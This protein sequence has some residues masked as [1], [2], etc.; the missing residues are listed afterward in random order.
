MYIG[1]R[2]STDDFLWNVQDHMGYCEDSP[3]LDPFIYCWKTLDDWDFSKIVTTACNVE[4]ERINSIVSYD[5]Y[6]KDVNENNGDDFV[7]FLDER[8]ANKFY[9]LNEKLKPYSRKPGFNI[10]LS[11]FQDFV[12]SLVEYLSEFIDEIR[13][14]HFELISIDKRGDRINV[15]ITG[16]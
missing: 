13:L 1:L 15:E 14:G 6:D 16:V 2:V 4:I 7:D 3:E 11:D 5:E 12:Y 8:Y 10:D 9:Q